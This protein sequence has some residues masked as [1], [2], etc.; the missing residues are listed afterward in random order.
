MRGKLQMWTGKWGTRFQNWPAKAV[1][2]KVVMLQRIPIYLLL[3]WTCFA[4][5]LNIHLFSRKRDKTIVLNFQSG[6]G[7]VPP[8]HTG[9]YTTVQA[10]FAGKWQH[11]IIWRSI[12]KFVFRVDQKTRWHPSIDTRFNIQRDRMTSLTIS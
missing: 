7:G 11:H 4:S 9:S 12:T 6:G 2:K 3:N 10:L 5:V 1:N 8:Y